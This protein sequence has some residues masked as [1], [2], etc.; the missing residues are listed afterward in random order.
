MQY[1]FNLRHCNDF[2]NVTNDIIFQVCG[3]ASGIYLMPNLG[4]VRQDISKVSIIFRDENIACL[5]YYIDDINLKVG[6]NDIIF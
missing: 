3:Q 4:Q 5:S 2:R 1:F 6:N